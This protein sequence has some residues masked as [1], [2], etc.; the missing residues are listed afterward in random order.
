MTNHIGQQLG[1]YRLI[2]FLG[3]GGFADVY[4]GE[5][6]YL[7][8][9]AAI[10]ILHAQLTEQDLK[11]FLQEAQIIARLK[12]PRIVR[13]FDFGVDSSDGTPYLVMDFAPMGTMRDRHPRGSLLP[14][15]TVIPYVKQIAAALQHAH[16]KKLIHRDVKPENILLKSEDQV[17][18]SDFG[19]AAV[20]HGT[21][22]LKTQ[23]YSGT[24]HYSAP[25]QIQ[26]KPRPASDQYALAIV[27][28]EWLSGSRP[29]SGS[30][31]I[32]IAMQHISKPA[33]S[34]CMKV[35]T[36]L[37]VVEQ[38]VLKALAKD[39]HQRFESVQA[40]ANAL[41]QVYQ[42]PSEALSHQKS[43][44]AL[45]R[46]K[47]SLGT[48]LRIHRGHHDEVYAVAWSPDGRYIA[49]ISRDGTMQV[50]AAS[51]GESLCTYTYD[52]E[53]RFKMEKLVWSPNKYGMR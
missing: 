17:V 46:Q 48:T 30:S 23:R 34:L 6:V 15:T 9:Q 27:V 40:F 36:I 41:E 12:H 13:I 4:L 44:E 2:Q 25:E 35:P 18:L 39:P 33:P 16:D 50:W 7:K 19:I 5:H 53:Y 51:T 45:S 37:P 24:V 47:P 29:F 14:L 8:T 52:A 32:E 42:K 10:K 11:D 26:G 31:H 22:S 28:Y 43:S 20:A 1:N 49:S 38:V 21:S 3:R